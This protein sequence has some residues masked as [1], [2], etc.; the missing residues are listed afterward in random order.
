MNRIEKLQAAHELIKDVFGT[1]DDTHTTCGCCHKPTYNNWQEHGCKEW[2]QACLGR[3]E[4][5]QRTLEQN[6]VG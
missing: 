6:M 3:I 4:R 2:P 1:L 5:V